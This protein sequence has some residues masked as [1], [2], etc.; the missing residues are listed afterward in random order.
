MSWNSLQIC[1]I[2]KETILPSHVWDFFAF[3]F[4]MLTSLVSNNSDM[5]SHQL[6][7]IWLG[8]SDICLAKSYQASL[9]LSSSTNVLKLSTSAKC[10]QLFPKNV[11]RGAVSANKLH[12]QGTRGSVYA[13]ANF[14]V[15]F[16]IYVY[17]FFYPDIFPLWLIVFKL[18]HLEGEQSRSMKQ[19]NM[20]RNKWIEHGF[21]ERAFARFF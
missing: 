6:Q 5:S 21:N 9:P 11:W 16:H 14:Y 12:S 20:A 7:P 4:K 15:V 3:C 17:S 8:T 19:Q 13:Y 1:D 2:K 10:R 18:V